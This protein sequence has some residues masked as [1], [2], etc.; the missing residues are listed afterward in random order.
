MNTEPEWA[1]GGL[2][3]AVWKVL[4]DALPCAGRVQCRVLDA[5]SG[6]GEFSSRLTKAGY[7]AIACDQDKSVFCGKCSRFVPCDLNSNWADAVRSEGPFDAVVAQ[8]VIEHIENP[9]RLIRDIGSLL[10]PGG[11]FILTSPNDQDK[12]SRI[13]FLF[14]G[15]LPWFRLDKLSQSG[16]QTPMFVEL[17]YLMAI[18]AG[19]ALKGFYGYGKR[20]PLKLN[21]K[22]RLFERYLDR[23]MTG[24]CLNNVINIWVFQ[25]SDTAL[26][27]LSHLN[28]QV[29]AEA[30]KWKNTP[31]VILDR[32]SQ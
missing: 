32:D 29:L 27:G 10:K 12:A 4:Q 3:D 8:E 23:K 18:T 25:R 21:W 19:L 5:G 16:H 1:I 11:L 6:P 22:G 24:V 26:E 2:H 30:K 15:E 31:C 13:D 28:P 7:V 14:H 17:I 20:A 9:T